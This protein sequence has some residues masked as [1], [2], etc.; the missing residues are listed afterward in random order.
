M[1]VVLVWYRRRSAWIRR[2]E[3]RAYRFS[4][5]CRVGHQN[6]EKRS[7]SGGDPPAKITPAAPLISSTSWAVGPLWLNV[8]S[9]S[10]WRNDGLA[11]PIA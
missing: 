9:S 6:S 4:T 10:A 7:A 5:R 8:S 11:V 1:T 3:A 2:G